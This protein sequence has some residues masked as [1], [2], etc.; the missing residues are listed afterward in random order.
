MLYGKIAGR[1]YHLSLGEGE[2][3]KERKKESEAE[4][5]ADRVHPCAGGG[6]S[7]AK[8]SGGY[9]WWGKRAR[10]RARVK[11]KSEKGW[12]EGCWGRSDESTGPTALPDCVVDS[13]RLGGERRTRRL[14]GQ[15]RR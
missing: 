10:E 14:A 12:E 4:G 7:E 11:R 6:R 13:N 8:R 9:R 2:R 1:E 3:K 15:G 5:A